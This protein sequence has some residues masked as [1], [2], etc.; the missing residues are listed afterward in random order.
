VVKP[1]KNGVNKDTVVRVS[2][3]R[4]VIAACALTIASGATLPAQE[5]TEQAPSQTAGA[6]GAQ[7]NP[8]PQSPAPLIF[9]VTV[10]G[11]TPLPGS[12]LPVDRIPAPV[13]TATSRD[14]DRS[15]AL[16]LSD[17][18]N[19]RLNAVYI[20][21]VQNNPFQP[22]VN[23]RGYTAS[24][25]LGTPQ[26][27]SVYMDGVRLNQPFGDIVSWDLIPRLAI[28][29]MAVMP[30][31]NPLFGLNT[32]GGALALETKDGVR[33]PG[34]RVHAIYGSHTR[35]AV[36]FE[37]GGSQ[38][39]GR[40]HWY[41]AGN[42]FD[43]H[44]WREDSPSQ[45][46][47]L[48]GKVGWRRPRTEASVSAAYADNSLNG[49]GLQETGFL[50]REYSSVYTKPDTTENR[51]TFVNASARHSVRETLTLSGTVYYR[52][53]RANTLNGDL[54]EDS[55]DQALYQPS[56]AE[57]AA[58]AA[59]GYSGFPASGETAE[60]TPF[61]Y[62][63]CLGNVLLR[64]EP[65]EKCNGLINRTTTGQHNTGASGQLTWLSR[66]DG[67]GHHV[68]AG[69]GYD[70][71]SAHFLQS[72]ELGYLNPDRSVTGTNAFADGVTGG[73]VDGEPFDARVDL[74][75]HT[76]TV[77]LYAT[78]TFRIRDGIH[79]TLS[80]RFNRT[81]VENVDAITP[82][83]GTGSLD[84]THT[85]SRFNPAA[86]V[87][88]ALPRRVNAYVGYSEGSR[89]ATSI[90]L[91]CA[92]P[93]SP[94]KLP[95]AMAG[96][97]PLDQVVTRTF[98]AGLRGAQRVR[99]NAGYFRA[100]NRD[101]ILFVMS[102]QTGFGY[103]RNF[104]RTRRQGL[105]LGADTDLG[106]VTLGVDYTFLDA[107]FQSPETLNGESNSS[108][109]TGSGLEGTIDI[110]PGA[111]MPLIPR[112]VF[113]AFGELTIRSNLFVELGLVSASRSYA[114]GNENN[115]HQ[116]DG[117][118][119]FGDGATPGYAVVNLGARYQLTPRIGVLL[120][121]NNLFD[122]EYATASQ[123][124]VNGFT[125]ANTFIARPFP[126]TGGEFPLRH[127]TFVAPGAPVAAWLGVRLTL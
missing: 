119:Y 61:P 70:Y 19:R 125:N 75:G 98:E 46:G 23:Y 100:G 49:N 4:V 32:L 81:V 94:C 110:E 80:G 62:W 31:S 109:D 10:V 2:R 93:E 122:S 108:N 69:G 42:L 82:G 87:T 53:I 8:A 120:Q 107:T 103:F 35:R 127:G 88:I 65:G 40:L 37:H 73:E 99:W 104:G 78:D 45:V 113:K 41:V 95:N 50:D 56:A 90:E 97:P 28:S 77:S 66:A 91:G 112:H 83:G 105:E 96:D 84:G 25:L 121:V 72:S 5:Q 124:G 86:G 101:D 21:E 114:R 18:M 11:N 116:S 106:R 55:L 38:A 102:E 24:P 30:G 67:A 68:T 12:D 1:E 14:I 123:L 71:N 33:A 17:F 57:R 89:A 92:D 79:G 47:Q 26:G 63:R 54:N 13:Q 52:H 36:E 16:D 51:S 6:S 58:L 111:R 126:S 117:V 22:D 3:T 34:T 48:F 20:N 115:A 74:D 60:N 85:F 27:I 44:G 7:A 43:E 39:A 64:D 9:N 29:S 15:G 118:Y 76:R 59:A